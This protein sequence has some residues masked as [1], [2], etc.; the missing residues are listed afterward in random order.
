ML[1]KHDKRWLTYPSH[2]IEHLNIFAIL[3]EKMKVLLPN[4]QITT[5]THIR[6]PLKPNIYRFH[7][8][9]QVQALPY[10]QTPTTQRDKGGETKIVSNF[11][12]ICPFRQCLHIKE[13]CTT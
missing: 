13:Y 12:R 10:H 4:L 3:E 2:G 1:A 7:A 5:P 8:R 9:A 11:Q 6:L